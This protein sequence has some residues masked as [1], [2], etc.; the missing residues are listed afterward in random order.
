[1]NYGDFSKALLLH[2]GVVRL[3]LL[4]DEVM[5]HIAELE[6]SPLN[7][8]LMPIDP[9]GLH[10]ISKKRLQLILFCSTEFP[11]FTEPFIDI[12]DGRG[13]LIGHDVL[14]K[15]KGEYD[16]DDYI[17]LTNNIFFDLTKM[18][19]YGIRGVIHSLSLD[20]KGVPD[21]VCPR[22]YYPCKATADWLNE[23]YDAMGRISATVLVG[24]N[25]VEF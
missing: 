5:D 24:V 9:E 7:V 14:D 3:E 19:E 4:T 22:V 8:G 25:G 23:R 13:N 17:W 2:P 10:D 11:M 18:T 21:N 1:M 12:V 20:V 16:S 6:H 15:D